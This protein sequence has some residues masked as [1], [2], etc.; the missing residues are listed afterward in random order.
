MRLTGPTA[1]RLAWAALALLTVAI[2]APALDAPPYWDANVYFNQARLTVEDPAALRHPPDGALKP[3]VFTSLVAGAAY[4]L[5]PG[6]RA[7]HVAVVGFALALLFAVG[8]LA[9]ALGG[10][11]RTA[12]LAGLLCAT[13]PLYV[14]QAGL[15]QSDLPMTALLTWAWVALLRGRTAAWLVLSALAVLTKESAYFVCAPALVFLWLQSG[16]SLPATARRLVLAAWPGLVLLGW[17]VALRVLTGSAVP[18]INRDA[19]RP[20]YVVDA[21]I[22]ELVEGGRL[23]L[24]VLAAL[25]LRLAVDDLRVQAARVATAVA[26]VAL[27]LFF[28]APLPRYMLPGLPLLCALA[29]LALDGLSPR[30]RRL[31]TAALVATQVIGWFGPSWHSNGGHHLDCNLRWRRLVG[32]QRQVVDAVAAAHPRAVAAA[33]PFYWA[34]VD[35]PSAGWL[36]APLPV[37]AADP[38]T[39]T[40][41]LCRADFF[42][43]PD[44]SVPLDEV[45]A[46]LGAALVPWRS[47]GPPGLS[48]RVWRVDCAAAPPRTPPTPPPSTN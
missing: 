10:G 20:N 43:D 45:R 44:Q 5:W 4:R 30:P 39:P 26:V 7:L 29:A 3:P 28:F 25:A 22:H 38:S 48:V 34:F 14:A 41:A 33:F 46:R 13:A 40:A 27:P 23:P 2:A 12:L 1:R 32:V 21:L 31:V 6:Q 36:P 18:R 19:L 24:V 15:V 11:E 42:V 16:R 47:F 35:P 8:A 37:V 17:L 9:R